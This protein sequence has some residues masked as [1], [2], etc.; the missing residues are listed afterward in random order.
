M[1]EAAK[2]Q[3]RGERKQDR[4]ERVRILDGE[5]P[6]IEVTLRGGYFLGKA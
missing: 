4:R 1:H 2:S 5:H 6:C 3:A